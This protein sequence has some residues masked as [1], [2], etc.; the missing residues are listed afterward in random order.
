MTSEKKRTRL[1]S[2]RGD[3]GKTSLAFG[4]RVGKDHRRIVLSGALEELS[5]Q[6]GWVRA[7]EVDPDVDR[8]LKRLLFR[9]HE[10]QTE[11][12][13]VTPAKLAVK[14]V[15]ENDIR[16]IERVIDVWDAKLNPAPKSLIPGGCKTGAAI[17]IAR[18]LCRRAERRACALLRFD[19]SFSPRVG[20][21]LNRVGDL[22]WVLARFENSRLNFREESFSACEDDP[23]L[24]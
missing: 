18:T 23:D 9:I 20:A 10:V 12:L 5:A 24:F 17:Q 1:Y 13:S 19:P 11:V 15:V 21:W 22:L 8:V 4:P 6:I 16:A 3:L 2:R 14:L 7:L